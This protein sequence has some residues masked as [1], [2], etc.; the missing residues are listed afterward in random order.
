MSFNDNNV[1]GGAEMYIDRNGLSGSDID[2]V[3]RQLS[4]QLF[5]A[6]NNFQS[7][8]LLSF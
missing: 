6:L 7:N 1:D 2:C 3:C 8:R 5:A 4:P